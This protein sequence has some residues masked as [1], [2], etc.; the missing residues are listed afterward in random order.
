MQLPVSLPVPAFQWGV[1][2]KQYLLEELHMAASRANFRTPLWLPVLLG[3]LAWAAHAETELPAVTVT[4]NKQVQSLESVAA[5]VSV[6]DGEDL[7]AAGVHGL[8]G[9]AQMTPGFIFQ[10]SGQS[11]LQPPVMRGLTGNVISFSSSTAL[12]VD[13]V[14]T[15]R[16][17]GFDDNLLGV[18]RVEV[19]RGPQS[20]LYGRNA[21]TGVV[22]IVTRKPGNDPY[23]VISVDLGSRNKRAVR[24][25]LSRALVKDTLYL[26]IAGELF[27]QDGFIDNAFMGR[28]EDDRERRNGRLALRWTPGA[29]TDATL[30]YAQRDYR[31]DGSQWGAVNAPRGIVRSGTDSRSD[32]TARTLSLDVSHEFE[33]GLRLRSITARNEFLDRVTQDTDFMPTDMLHVGRNHHFRT[34]SQEFRLEGKLGESQWLAG[35]Y[36][37]RDDHDLSFEQKIPLRLTTTAAALGGNSTALFTHW[38]IPLTAQWS[39]TTGARIESNEVRFT[40]AIGAE[41][42]QDSTRFSPKVALQYQWQPDAQVY[43][44]VADGFRAGGFNAFAPTTRKSYQPELVRSFEL[45]AKGQL[46]ARRLRYGTS[47]YLMNVRDM[48]VQQMGMPGQVFITNA[49]SARSVGAEAEFQYLLGSGWQVQAALGLNRTRFREFQD[50]VNSFDGN[51]NP[52][53]PDINGHIGVRYDAPQ[54]WYTQAHIVG[55]GKIYLDA[56]NRFSRAGYGLINLAAGYTIGHGELS[57]YVHNAGNKQ[58][59]AIGF[60]NGLATVYSPPRELGLRLAYRW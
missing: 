51:H 12:V 60:L 17:Q 25:D 42:S 31:D 28:K 57:A 3:S 13:G 4:A 27:Q 45:G 39:V 10:S 14:P 26:G 59:D 30:R 9:V 53:A 11:G 1:T 46:L 41:Q 32:S 23:A 56:A 6:F 18:E 35:L 58:Y 5:S 29:D 15:L 50:G 19:L 16:G 52:F 33:S 47:V 34:L 22:S 40:P 20:T 54:G 7:E 8:E 43:A 44:S 21:E 55:T 48:Q 38:I 2:R 37:D 24:F 49:A 36:A